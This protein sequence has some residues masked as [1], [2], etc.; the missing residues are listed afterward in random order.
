[1]SLVVSET[2]YSM[3]GEGISSGHPSVFIRLAGCN[4]LCEGDGWICDSIP[5]WRKGEKKPFEQVLTEGQIETLKQGAHLIFTGGEPMLHH[6]AIWEYMQ[7]LRNKH[8]I[9]PYTEIETNGTKWDDDLEYFDQINCS[10]KLANSGET[11]A[12]RFKPEVLE[13][14]DYHDNA[15]FKFV[16]SR[17]EDWNEIEETFLG[18]ISKEKIILMPAGDS[19]ESLSKT[20][21]IVA[22]L[23]LLHGV[24]YC[25]RLQVVIWNQTTGV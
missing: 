16:I 7:W 9:E 4:L 22:K 14:I 13:N 15:W 8:G 1:M 17:E 11:I 20:R 19:I 18:T 6:E 21:P 2:F 10:P 3:Q 23:A 24:K 12:R 25:D 5:V